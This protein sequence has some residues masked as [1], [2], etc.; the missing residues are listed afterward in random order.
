MTCPTSPPCSSRC[1][2]STSRA[3]ASGARSTWANPTPRSADYV[4]LPIRFDGDRPYI[5][6]RDEWTVEE[7]AGV[8]DPTRAGIEREPIE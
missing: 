4:W 1:S 3:R 6:W 5:E 8:A 7:F 2:A